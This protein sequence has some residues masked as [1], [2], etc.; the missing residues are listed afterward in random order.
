M[1]C[2]GGATRRPASSASRSPTPTA[3]RPCPV[4][5]SPKPNTEVTLHADR[6]V[7]TTET[8]PVERVRLGKETVTEQ[9]TVGGQVRKEEI[10]LDNRR[11]QPPRRRPGR[12][13]HRPPLI[14]ST[15]RGRWAGS[16]PAHRPCGRRGPPANN[17]ALHL[18]S[19]R[20]VHERTAPHEGNRYDRERGHRRHKVP[21]PPA[22]GPRATT[23]TKHDAANQSATS[24][25]VS[26]AGFDCDDRSWMPPTNTDVRH[27]RIRW[28]AVWTGVLT[29]LSIYIDPGAAV[30]RPRLARP[31]HQRRRRHHPRRDRQRGARPDRLLPRPAPLPVPRACGTGPATP[32]PTASS[33]GPSP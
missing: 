16:R 12:R 17:P 1:T 14:S 4:R 13:P 6:P 7:T 10:E 26:R 19:R 25:S 11:S 3:T 21:T 5:T 15:T 24:H 9:E 29:A 33:P 22:T 18:P 27:D 30:L 20:P 28:G 31:G 23:P 2:P 8:V 32:W